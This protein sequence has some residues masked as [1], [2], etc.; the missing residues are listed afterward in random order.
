MY[1]LVNKAIQDLVLSEHGA[2]VWGEIVRTA[3][4]G[5]NLRKALSEDVGFVRMDSYPDG[6]TFGLVKTASEVLGVPAS[7]LLE[8][9]GRYWIRYTAREGYGELLELSGGSLHEFLSNLDNLH[10]RVG[11]SLPDLQ[12][13]SFEC[14]EVGPGRFELYYRS[15]RDGLAP[16]VVGLVKGL[17]ERFSVEVE[18]RQ[19][20]QGTGPGEADIFAIEVRSH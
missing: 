4:V 1:G 17:A 9:F 15:S 6:V 12:P 7:D 10:T 16:M 5:E 13:P 8:A 18:V 3:D 2:E 20:G 11:L 19:T 14:R